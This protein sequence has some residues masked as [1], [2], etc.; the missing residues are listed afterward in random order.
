MFAVSS[1][2]P[3]HALPEYLAAFRAKYPAASGSR[4]DSCTLCHG[5][6]PQLNSYGNAF[7]SAGRKLA[8]IEGLDSDGD[9]ATNL[10]EIVALTFPGD[11]ADTPILPSPTPTATRPPA[12]P[13]TTAT[14]TATATTPTGSGH[15]PGDCGGNG[16]VT[17]DEL[18]KAVNIALGT[19]GVTSCPAV[20]GD[21]NGS[22]TIA[23]LLQAVN[24]ALSGCP[25]VR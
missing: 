19:L 3:A 24:A 8:T 6:V 10:V 15:C 9:G 21:G 5:A 22:V 25:T 1:A 20:D 14:A 16:L 13:T 17:V 12:T 4:I 11:P 23:E 2:G 7:K 18:L